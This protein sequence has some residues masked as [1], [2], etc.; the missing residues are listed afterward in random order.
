MQYLDKSDTRLKLALQV[1]NMGMWEWNLLTGKVAWSKNIE[2]LFG[3]VP[4]TWQGNYRDL[5]KR[6]CEKDRR[7]VAGSIARAIKKQANYQVE[8]RIDLPDGTSRWLFSQGAVEPDENN[9]PI[10][11]IGFCRDITPDQQVKAVRHRDTSGYLH[12]KQLGLTSDALFHL[13]KE[14]VFLEVH[15]SENV[16]LLVPSSDLI[17]KSLSAVMPPEIAQQFQHYLRQALFTHQPQIFEYSLRLSGQLQYFQARMGVRDSTEVLVVVR[18][19]T[20]YKK[21]EATLHLS[22]QRFSTILNS[23]EEI[24][25]SGSVDTLE[26]LDLNP[27]AEAIY[28]RPIVEFFENQDLWLEIIH[29]E[30]RFHVLAKRQK[31]LELGS[32]ELE[33]RIVRPCGEIRW[34]R[35]RI[36][37]IWDA[38]GN[39][40]SLEGIATDITRQQ[41]LVAAFKQ[42]SAA[43]DVCLSEHPTTVEPVL[44]QMRCAIAD[45]LHLP[46]ERTP[47]YL[48]NCELESISNFTFSAASNSF[49]QNLL[50]DSDETPWNQVLLKRNGMG[51]DSVQRFQWESLIQ[52][53]SD[54]IMMVSDQGSILYTSP[55]IE[56]ILRYCPTELVGQSVIQYVAAQ[57]REAIAKALKKLLEVGYGVTLT[58]L[59]C[60]FVTK[61]GS[62]CFL[63]VTG[64][65]LLADETLSSIVINARDV[66]ERF[67]VQEAL[68]QSEVRFRAIFGGAALGIALCEPSGELLVGN[69]ALHKMFGYS[70]IELR[71]RTITHPDDI[72][73]DFNLYQQLLAGSIAS[74]QMEKRY[75]H[76]SGRL[77]WGRLSVSLVRDKAGNPLFIVCMVE[78]ITAS[79][80]IEAQLLRI[81]KAVENS[82]DAISIADTDMSRLSYL[83]PAFCQLF[84]Y[85]LEQLNT[86]GGYF[87]LFSDPQTMQEVFAI[88]AKGH[89]W[90]GEIEMLDCRGCVKQI[91]LRADAI[92]DVN[93]E[94]VGT[95]AIH[96]DITERKQAEVQLRRS[97]YRA[98]LLK[99]ITT[100][101]RSSLDLD[102][103]FNTTVMQVG[104]A[105]Q[106][107]RCMILLYQKEVQPKLCVAAEYLESGYSSM[108][109]FEVPVEGNPHAQRVLGT[110]QAIAS[111]DVYAEP[112]LVPVVHLCRAMDI[113]SMVAIRISYQ[114]EPNGILG[115]HQCDVHRDWES[116]EIELLEAV[117]AQVGIAL[118]QAHLLE[119]EKRTAAKLAEQNL[120]LQLS[121]ARANSKAKELEQALHDLQRTQAQLVQT[122]KM[123]SLGQLVAGVAH[124]INNPVGFII[125]N[126]NYACDYIQDLLK[127]VTLYRQHYPQPP[128]VIQ[129]ELQAIEVDFLI[130]DL[131]KLLKSMKVGTDRINQIV[132]SLRNFSRSDE[133]EMK[134]VDIHEGIDN[135]LLILRHRLKAQGEDREINVIKEYSSLPLVEGYAGQL[136]QVFMNL[137]SNAIDA[138][139]SKR[140]EK[141]RKIFKTN[142][143]AQEQINH[144]SI[145]SPTIKI[146]TLAHSNNRV[147]IC[148]QDNGPGMTDE[149]KK[150]VFT[151]F[152]TTKPIGKGT[153]LGLSISYQIVV[154]K[155]SGEFQCFSTPGEGTK[156]IIE[157]PIRQNFN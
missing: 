141:K 90:Q 1:A 71:Q 74:Y 30:D 103:I 22:Q 45:W 137:L 5:L 69:P 23:L 55:S 21:T 140:K 95:I 42:T 38:D 28:G 49:P 80:H 94:V 92:K 151:P 34:L 8:F 110:D 123:S 126:I 132:L 122:E 14:G 84:G 70:D 144:S 136:N 98:E 143:E 41:R 10:K 27:A 31:L 56:R 113:K 25:W 91:A 12:L 124:E 89:S 32:A 17:G 117:A 154:E 134:A 88:A 78:D 15:P 7:V 115:L 96:T 102:Q 13:N 112:L 40:T 87:V 6:I 73:T 97:Y 100:E 107:N 153:G 20:E 72:A 35:D 101:I 155:H 59:I 39:P 104:Q 26:L 127:I 24:I 146:S 75:F 131:P 18:N 29:P 63:E 66:T 76:K 54:L 61:D 135:T 99:Q 44:E 82:S 93:G 114:G 19:I 108:G 36:R 125:G 65:N 133:G 106:V 118:Y 53:S 60:R 68:R 148:I 51:Q 116:S 130:K 85:T 77:V 48:E 111:V 138:L 157:I 147:E 52:Q 86:V 67:K 119:K 3:V 121:E 120:A 105:L 16:E 64:T 46:P 150:K 4:G 128:E 145:Y 142:V 57:D 152:F 139:E 37:V 58:P 156:F 81:G 2:Q 11:I 149:V 79:K 43:L 83:N 47:R 9:Q 62:W 129:S 50:E 109:A 33:Y